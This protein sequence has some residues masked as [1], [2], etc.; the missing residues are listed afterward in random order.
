MP[1]HPFAV[2][3][4]T[5]SISDMSPIPVIVRL[6]R[7]FWSN[8]PYIASGIR[9][10]PT[11]RHTELTGTGSLLVQGLVAILMLPLVLANGFASLVWGPPWPFSLSW[12]FLFAC[13]GF[14]RRFCIDVCAVLLLGR[15]GCAF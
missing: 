15:F 9:P 4:N 2:V 5:A 11:G 12:A 8:S 14:G 3:S 1:G 10:R 13:N 7:P 6:Y